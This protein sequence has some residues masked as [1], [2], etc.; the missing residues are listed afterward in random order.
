MRPKEPI[1][2]SDMVETSI[3]RFTNLCRNANFAPMCV[4]CHD[5]CPTSS[6]FH[7]SAALHEAVLLGFVLFPLPELRKLPNVSF[8]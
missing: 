3:Q 1:V 8:P 5:A 4:T 2:S 7:H 6:V